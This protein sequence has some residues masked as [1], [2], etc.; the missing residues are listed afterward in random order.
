MP[1]NDEIDA[2]VRLSTPIAAMSVLDFGVYLIENGIVNLCCVF[3]FVY[4][5]VHLLYFLLF[6]QLFLERLLSFLDF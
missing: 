3:F 4:L 2:V 6:F 1:N 5:F